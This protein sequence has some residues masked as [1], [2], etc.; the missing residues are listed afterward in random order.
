[1]NC[2]PLLAISVVFKKFNRLRFLH[3][4]TV[5][6]REGDYFERGIDILH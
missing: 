6:A 5:I 2:S 3:I 1:M 4:D